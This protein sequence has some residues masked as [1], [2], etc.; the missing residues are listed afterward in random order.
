MTYYD[1]LSPR[2]KHEY[3]ELKQKS[4]GFC[5]EENVWCLNFCLEYCIPSTY[6][7]HPPS[8]FVMAYPHGRHKQNDDLRQKVKLHGILARTSILKIS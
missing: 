5:T 7:Q 2:L 4:L 8:V 1:E 3:Q 6:P